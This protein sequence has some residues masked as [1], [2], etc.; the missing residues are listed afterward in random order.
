MRLKILLLALFVISAASCK[1]SKS[2]EDALDGEEDPAPDPEADPVPDPVSD[3][4]P[5]DGEEEALPDVPDVE[6]DG[7]PACAEHAIT[8][9]GRTGKPAFAPSP[10]SSTIDLPER[11]TTPISTAARTMPTTFSDPLRTTSV[12]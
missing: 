6:S 12:K 1:E 11:S 9:G 7:P 2:D 5:G 3:D 10:K 4:D 8:C